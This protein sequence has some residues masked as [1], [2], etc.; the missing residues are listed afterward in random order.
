[1][2]RGEK[3]ITDKSDMIEILENSE[4]LYLAM[5]DGDEPYVLPLNYGFKGDM[6]YIHC[7]VEGKKLEMLKKN[8]KVCFTVSAHT[9][10]IKAESSCAWTYGFMSVL[11]RGTAEIVTDKESKVE[12]LDI[13][14][15]HYGRTENTYKDEMVARTSLIRIKISEMTG[16]RSPIKKG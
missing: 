2:R 7:A 13:I 12:G 11:C 1:M 4:V 9:Q 3:E 14:M 5:A 6:V 16:K 8:P 10:L 15:A